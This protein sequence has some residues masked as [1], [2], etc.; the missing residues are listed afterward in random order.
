[1][2]PVCDWQHNRA[3]W[4]RVLQESTG[5]D[6]DSWNRH[7]ERVQPTIKQRLDLGLRLESQAPVW[8]L[9]P[10]RIH[11]TMKLQISFT[12]LEEVDAEA[13][14]WLEHAYDQNS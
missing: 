12:A 6:P 1:M 9:Q 2:N 10:S 4:I 5:Q 3:M 13:L 14:A 11:E 8:R 7:I